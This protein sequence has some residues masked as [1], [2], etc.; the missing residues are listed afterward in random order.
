MSHPADSLPATEVILG[1]LAAPEVG[2]YR[3][4]LEAAKK[5]IAD[6]ESICREGFDYTNGLEQR[7]NKL[8]Q[9]LDDTYV[10]KVHLERANK[11]QQEQLQ[12]FKEGWSDEGR[13][14]QQVGTLDTQIDALQQQMFNANLDNA[15][16]IHNLKSQMADMA[17]THEATVAFLRGQLERQQMV[18][19]TLTEGITKEQAAVKEAR[20]DYDKLIVYY[21]KELDTAR[22]NL[23]DRIIELEELLDDANDEIKRLKEKKD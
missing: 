12:S 16:T 18:I 1:G 23:F 7:I 8:Q 5:R 4:E 13:L 9:Q 11:V 2:T 21:E 14:V 6:L 17:T 22:T 10:R 3:A 15:E 19:D 20:Q